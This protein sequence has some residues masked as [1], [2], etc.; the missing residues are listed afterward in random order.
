[1]NSF[2]VSLLI[3][4]ISS[5]SLPAMA[6]TSCKEILNIQYEMNSIK[7]KVKFISELISK[8]E[9]TR[10][11]EKIA[12]LKEQ[13]ACTKKEKEI[14]SKIKVDLSSLEE[15]LLSLEDR[16]KKISISQKTAVRLF[17]EMK[18]GWRPEC[19]LDTSLWTILRIEKQ[20]EE[21]VIFKGISDTSSL[22]MINFVNSEKSCSSN[23]GECSK[24]VFKEAT[25]HP[26]DSSLKAVFK[27]RKDSTYSCVLEVQ[28]L[29]VPSKEDFDEYYAREDMLNRKAD[30][31]L[32]GLP[33]NSIVAQTVKRTIE[34][35]KKIGSEN[36]WG[37]AELEFTLNSFKRETLLESN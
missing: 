30:E 32:K 14:D 35:M 22:Y 33:S 29:S 19:Y 12:D 15:T 5:Y 26:I 37:P 36:G 9:K 24:A 1:M 7:E 3:F 20:E 27:G 8:S 10:A 4:L 2:S 31:V 23:F 13:I 16:A 28:F 18:K 21:S 11:Q 34:E 25:K 6:K 17:D